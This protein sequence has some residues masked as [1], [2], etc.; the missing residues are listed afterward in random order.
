[1]D[2]SK[3]FGNANQQRLVQETFDRVLDVLKQ[4]G[5]HRRSPKFFIVYAHENDNLDIKAH[6]TV[7]T[8]YISWFKEIQFNV[9]SDKSPH[10]YGPIHDVAHAGASVDIVKNQV[11]LLPRSWHKENVDYVLVFYSELLAHYMEVE[12]DFM[13]QGQTY[14]DALFR[15]CDRF[16]HTPPLPWEEVCSAVANVQQTYLSKMNNEFHHV[17][18]E[19]ALLKFRQSIAGPQYT[20]PVLL[21]DDKK[22]SRWKPD[23]SGM[24]ETQIR[25]TLE[26]GKKHQLFFKI[27]LMFETLENDRP[28][29]EALQACYLKCVGLLSKR[30]LQPEKYRTQVEVEISQTLRNLNNSE[31]HWMIDRPITI[32]SIR[33]V[34]NLHSIINRI[35][36][37]RVSGKKLPE[38]LSDISLSVAE[39]PNSEDQGERW[40]QTVSIHSLFDELEL[41]GKKVLPR[42]VLIQGRP[43]VGK[44]T[45]SKRI[46]YEYCWD[47]KLRMKFDLVVRIPVRKLGQFADL[48]DL[49]FDEYFQTAAGGHEL[50]NRLRDLILGKANSNVLTILDGLDEARQWSPKKRS[51]LERLMS[52]PVVIMT[53][54]SYETGS[55]SVDLT[56]EAL[57]LDMEDVEEYLANAEIVQSN[58]GKQILNLIKSKYFI[59]E[60]VQVPIHLDILCYSWDELQRQKAL[61]MAAQNAEELC[62][63]TITA[64]YQAV[65]HTLWRKDI[66]GLGKLDNGEQLT[67]EVINAV[68]DAARLERVVYV[69]NSLLEEICINMIES[70]QFEFGDEDIVKAIRHIERNGT[71]LPL[72]LEFNLNK[73]SFLH[74]DCRSH[75]R[76]FSFIH[77]TFQEFFAAQWLTKGQQRLSRYIR[78]YKYSQ[79]FE[80]VWR[81]VPG[82]LQTKDNVD[83]LCFFFNAIQK[84]PRD[85]LG[86]AHQRLV[87]N[88]LSEVT[89]SEERT[90]FSTLRTELEV[91]LSKWLAFEYY[92][93]YHLP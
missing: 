31:Q 48:A 62:A 56:I 4:L 82:L 65:V 45:L 77:L 44:T 43:G 79:R 64:L 63:P 78:Q 55:V 1:M 22:Q 24:D 60:M 13:F 50:S 70:D 10:G 49:L 73:L 61:F 35:S 37:K 3:D 85:I 7:V 27:L 47:N 12:R 19:L 2:P 74:S 23:F 51:L 15:V 18:T 87:M 8:D 67:T 14:T 72:S 16:S 75:L 71:Q 58:T 89:P 88:L 38:N 83:Q 32:G 68:Q 90:R 93:K 92:H 86:P 6:K 39:N 25:L 9:D 5:L 91:Q 40:S 17:L 81:F 34:L 66:P 36:T 41:I 76:R 21:F 57:G 20:I 33:D 30:T 28:L 52:Q 26:P 69:E 53:S 46:M 11:C 59:E 42:R 29:I 80:R 54:R 84:E